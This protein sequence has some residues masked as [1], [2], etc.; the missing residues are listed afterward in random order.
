TGKADALLV[1]LEASLRGIVTR[2]DVDNLSLL[3]VCVCALASEGA[4]AAAIKYAEFAEDWCR[5]ADFTDSV[6][7]GTALSATAEMFS[8]LNLYGRAAR[9]CRR[10]AAAFDSV[11]DSDHPLAAR[12][13]RMHRS[14]LTKLAL[15]SR[16]VTK[17]AYGAGYLKRC[18]PGI[19]CPLVWDGPIL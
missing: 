1:K 13:R 19:L 11:L 6:A 9:L 7:T 17:P 18:E 2:V 15:D 12:S 16:K 5:R 3:N 4:C 10:A 8:C 14:F